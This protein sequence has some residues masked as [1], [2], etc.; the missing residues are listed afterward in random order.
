MK[1][2]PK[3]LTMPRQSKHNEAYRAINQLRDFIEYFI[4]ETEKCCT[5][6]GCPKHPRM[7]FVARNKEEI[8]EADRE[9]PL[10]GSQCN[11]CYDGDHVQCSGGR[12][13]CRCQEQTLA[14]KFQAFRQKNGSGKG[15]L[16]WEGLEQVASEHYKLNSL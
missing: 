5:C 9:T 2:L 14:K 16:Y 10:G 11:N 4:L 6:N 13:E 12:C 15:R 3:P 1:H 8:E 7:E